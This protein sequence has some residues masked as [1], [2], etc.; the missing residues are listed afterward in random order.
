MTGHLELDELADVLAGIPAPEHLDACETCLSR[1]AQLQGALP[2][3]ADSL[4]RLELPPEPADLER[5]LADALAAERAPHRTTVVPLSTRRRVRWMPTLAA[6]AAVAALAFGGVVLTQRSGDDP[7]T[8]RGDT[9]YAVSST[10]ADYGPDGQALRAA[11]PA[12]LEGDA[13][14]APES[15]TAFGAAK[16]S[17]SPSPSFTS[18]KRTGA[19]LMSAAPENDALATLRTQAGLA[20]CLVALADPDDPEV[21]LPLALDYA[22]YQGQPALVVV[23]PTSKDDKVDVFVVGAQCSSSDAKLLFFTR[24]TRP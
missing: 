18:Q 12:L 6:V 21:S 19:S 9:T 24:L 10:G 2:G 15:A 20:S 11:L 17:A 7:A 22:S 8:T 23:L 16:D 5:R 13:T 14:A 1:L 3:V 4:A